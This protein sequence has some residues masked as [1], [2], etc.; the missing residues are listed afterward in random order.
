MAEHSAAYFR[1]S[2]DQCG[3]LDLH[4]QLCDFGWPTLG[5]FAFS[6]SYMPGQPDDSAFIK[7]VVDRLGLDE[8]DPRVAGLRRLFFEAY[9]VSA[10][11]MRRRSCRLDAGV[12]SQ[13]RAKR[14]G[15][16]P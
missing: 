6:S 8:L 3:V 16:L 13:R 5:K 12:G 7:A 11:E 1:D 4:K 9:T 2:C 10:S 14:S 15:A